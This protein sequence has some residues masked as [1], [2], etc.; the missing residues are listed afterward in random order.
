MLLQHTEPLAFPP[1]GSAIA[2]LQ[3]ILQ[4]FVDELELRL[5]AVHP[6]GD[7]VSEWQGIRAKHVKLTMYSHNQRIGM[8]LART[9]L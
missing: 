7:K 4:I 6:G 2:R 3:I 9:R 1:R 8:F 5:S